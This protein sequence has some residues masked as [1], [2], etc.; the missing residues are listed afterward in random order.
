MEGMSCH[1]DARFDLGWRMPETCAQQATPQPCAGL[2][3]NLHLEGMQKRDNNREPLGVCRWRAARQKQAQTCLH[4]PPQPRFA[5]STSPFLL[6]KKWASLKPRAHL[7]TVV[8]LG[9]RRKTIRSRPTRVC[10]TALCPLVRHRNS[11]SQSARTKPPL[12]CGVI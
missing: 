2:D 8:F 1:I 4:Q 6:W 11:L 9:I 12:A 10:E 5:S 3:A 7:Q